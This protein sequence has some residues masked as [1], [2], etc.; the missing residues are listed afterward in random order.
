MKNTFP[1]DN[2]MEVAAKYGKYEGTYLDHLEERVQT[3]PAIP[4][5][6]LSRGS[7]TK[8]ELKIYWR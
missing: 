2:P 4:K 8:A 1:N 6:G 7:Q 5:R 3:L